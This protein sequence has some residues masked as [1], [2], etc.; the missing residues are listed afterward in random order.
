MVFRDSTLDFVRSFS[1]KIK[2]IKIMHEMWKHFIKKKLSII[3]Y[4][5]TFYVLRIILIYIY[6]VLEMQKI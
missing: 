1:D 3:I 5:N 2:T 6:L 4:L